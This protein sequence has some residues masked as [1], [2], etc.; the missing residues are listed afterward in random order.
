MTCAFFGGGDAG[1]GFTSSGSSLGICDTATSFTNELLWDQCQ[2][3]T[4]CEDVMK[5]RQVLPGA[6]RQLSH[7][8]PD[9]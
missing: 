8:I 9:S 3:L 2:L 6:P 1:S 7:S 4:R 5:S